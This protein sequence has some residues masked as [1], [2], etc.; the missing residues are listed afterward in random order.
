MF[1][2]F[3]KFTYYCS[4][5]NHKWILE[6]DVYITPEKLDEWLWTVKLEHKEF[7]KEGE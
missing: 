3:D 4:H 2:A 5:C 6:S 7:C 1:H